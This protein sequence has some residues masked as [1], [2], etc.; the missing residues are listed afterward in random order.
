MNEQSIPEYGF[1]RKL[2]WTSILSSTYGLYREHFWTFL[3]IGLPIA[4]L[5]YLFKQV[6]RPLVHQFYNLIRSTPAGPGWVLNPYIYF[7]VVIGLSFIK[8]AVYWILSTI[9]LAAISE[10]V[11][12]HD[13][14]SE[15]TPLSDAYSY[16]RRRL[17]ALFV[18][19]IV[20]WMPFFLLKALASFAGGK[21]LELFRIK[22]SQS[23]I[24]FVIV[25][26]PLLI[27]AG[28]F[29]RIGLAVPELMDNAAI[30]VRQ[31]IRNSFRKTEDWEPFFMFFLTKSAIV[32]YGVYWVAQRGF[33]LLWTRTSLS[34]SA[35]YWIT[36]GVY[37]C[38]FA[39]L[40]SPLF[41]AFSVLYREKSN[42]TQEAGLAAPAIG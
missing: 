35:Y 36:W 6:E 5:A 33:H 9:L 37:V 21:M 29:S 34:P 13:Q 8:G 30:S 4:I 17:K 7:P 24:S 16:V 38:L 23:L 14:Q 1:G 27:I 15:D 40:A 28:L 12:Q 42:V 22:P 39:L 20:T 19:G 3:R 11:T 18:F 10:K 2:T 26:L 25:S 32:G 41:I 31:A